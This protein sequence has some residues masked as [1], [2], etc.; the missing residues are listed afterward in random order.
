MESLLKIPYELQIVL[1]AGYIAYKVISIGKGRT[2]RTEDFLL[3]V[4]TFGL[5]ARSVTAGTIWMFSD[6]V[7]F[8]YASGVGRLF[9][10]M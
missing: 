6:F 9:S 5:V 7:A 8:S 3:Q 1:V 10:L 2:H 4:L